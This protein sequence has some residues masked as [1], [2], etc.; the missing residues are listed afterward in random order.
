MKSLPEHAGTVRAC[1]L[2]IQDE[3]YSETTR[4]G[5]KAYLDHLLED[6]AFIDDQLSGGYALP[7]GRE[8]DPGCPRCGCREIERVGEIDRCAGCGR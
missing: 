7:I 4:H 8:I 2:M 6:F 5:V 3:I 1:L